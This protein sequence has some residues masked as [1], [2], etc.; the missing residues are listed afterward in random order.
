[1]VKRLFYAYSLLKQEYLSAPRS[2]PAKNIILEVD[3]FAGFSS[4][5]LNY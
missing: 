4:L 2:S 5:Y 3:D 1:M